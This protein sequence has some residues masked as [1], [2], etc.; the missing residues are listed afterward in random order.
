MS[1]VAVGQGIFGKAV[2]FCMELCVLYMVGQYGLWVGEIGDLC[3]LKSL[4][5]LF[6]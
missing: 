6:R 1:N 5:L 4:N 3:I 2:M